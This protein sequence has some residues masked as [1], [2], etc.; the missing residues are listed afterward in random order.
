MEVPERSRFELRVDGE[1]RGLLD[2]R[3]RGERYDLHHTEVD[4]ALGGRGLGTR[5]VRAALDEL[6]A[7]D[8]TVVPTCSFVAAVID[9]DPAYASLR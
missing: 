3:F 7:R 6:V 4:P 2:Y 1:V 9:A 5:L 8:A